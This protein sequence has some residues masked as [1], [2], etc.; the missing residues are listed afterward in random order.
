MSEPRRFSL[1]ITAG[2]HQGTRRPI[3]TSVVVGADE[4]CDLVLKDAGVSG[5]HVRLERE[6]DTVFVLDLGST[7]PATLAGIPV[8]GRVPL[9]PGAALQLGTASLSVSVE[10]VVD[11]EGSAEVPVTSE[12]A[13]GLPLEPDPGAT[14]DDGAEPGEATSDG[15]AD[16]L[17]ASWTS[18]LPPLD[19][20]NAGR[21][22]RPPPHLKLFRPDVAEESPTVGMEIPAGEEPTTTGAPVVSPGGPEPALSAEGPDAAAVSGGVE[23]RDPVTVVP[24]PTDADATALREIAQV[25]RDVPAEIETRENAVPLRVAPRP[26]SAVRA[27]T[28]GAELERRWSA[29]RPQVRLGTLLGLVALLLVVS[30]AIG[31]AVVRHRLDALP[32]EPVQLGAGPLR[33][34]FGQG[35]GVDY[36]QRKEKAFFFE[37]HSPT[38]VA[39]FIHLQAKNVSNGELLLRANGEDVAWVQADPER[40]ELDLE[41]LVPHTLVH[42]G[43]KNQISFERRGEST[44]DGWRIS[45]LWVELYSVPD[46]SEEE[47]LR[48]AQQTLERAR[49]LFRDREISSENAFRAWKAAKEAWVLFASLPAPRRAAQEQVAQRQVE[50][51]ALELH[52]RCASLMLDARKSFELHDLE[53]AREILD[54]VERHFPTP[55]HRCHNLALK[56]IEEYGL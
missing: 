51:T 14:A 11:G 36:P 17:A 37:V 21:V 26:P 28:L 23:L 10:P 45:E 43:L 52:G 33:Y 38:A 2:L 49:Q 41:M 55:E 53:H 32:D 16:A 34:S 20:F 12:T 56:R 27:R 3:D 29:L 50:L 31:R 18:Q 8:V 9:A 7:N 1:S 40:P 46:V 4:A 13:V 15:E 19:A 42:R 22:S 54:D 30:V 35:A 44:D 48:R 39:A 24:D 25:P 6:G 5:R 47:R